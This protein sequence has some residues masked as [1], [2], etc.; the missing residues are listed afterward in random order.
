[1]LYDT[2]LQQT[3]DKKPDAFLRQL[4]MLD[5]NQRIQESKSRALPLGECPMRDLQ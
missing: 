1:M 5:S 3:K 4:G 2:S